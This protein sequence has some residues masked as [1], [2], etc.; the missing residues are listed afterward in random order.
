[1]LKEFIGLLL[2]AGGGFF[3]GVSP[4]RAA[5]GELPS[6][7][8]MNRFDVVVQG[9]RIIGGVG[10]EG[11]A[12]DIGIRDGR[13]A[14]MGAID[15]TSAE[16]VI[17][18]DG[19]DVTPGRAALSGSPVAA[20]LDPQWSW[21]KFLESGVTTVLCGDVR[22]SSRTMSPDS[23]E[24]GSRS[25]A[26]ELQL[27]S[28][29]GPKVNVVPMAG[30]NSL[31]CKALQKERIVRCQGREPIDSRVR[32]AMR[33]GA[34]GLAFAV[35]DSAGTAISNA[36]LAR[37]ALIVRQSCGRCLIQTAA[38]NNLCDLARRIDKVAHGSG[39]PVITVGD[40]RADQGVGD[41]IGEFLPLSNRGNIAVGMAADIVIRAASNPQ[42]GY[43]NS[44]APISPK[45]HYVLVNGKVA[46]REGKLTPG[47]EGHVLRGRG[48]DCTAKLA[49]RMTGCRDDRFKS[50]DILIQGF[51]EKHRLP[52]GAVAITDEG[53]L[54]YACGFGFADVDTRQPVRPD[55][56]FRIA[57]ISKPIT[58][59]AVMQ[60]VE[61]GKLELDSPVLSVLSH[62]LP[63]TEKQAAFDQRLHNVTIRQLLQHRAGWDREATFDPMFTAR[64]FA[65]A[66]VSRIPPSQDD[67][68][69]GMFTRPLDFTPGERYVYSNFGYCLLGRVIETLSQES[70]EEH[71]RRVVLTP[72]GIR[73]MTIGRTR[74]AQRR[75]AEVHYYDQ[76]VEMSILDV[77]PPRRVAAPYGAWSL[78]SMD[79]HGGW[80][81]SAV[82]LVR[83]AAAFDDP[84]H[85]ALLDPSSAK[86]MTERPTGLAGFDE[87]GIPRRVYYGLGWQVHCDDAGN[88][89]RQMHAGSLPGTSSVLVKTA[90]GRNLAIVFNARQS[91]YTSTP[92]PDL[93]TPLLEVLSHIQDWP[94]VDYFDDL[95]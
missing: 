4:L 47:R 68:I 50:V 29:F 26:E 90:S 30:F 25:L 17:D 66:G 33:A 85:C 40:S 94:E 76:G 79:S 87:E 27:L 7:D 95:Q 13:I 67:I 20:F 81:G 70:Y 5:V 59:V 91:P 14:A 89:L 75:P 82:D 23:D 49:R 64:R 12:C 16:E 42:E 6:V 53:R 46:I 44:D 51:L 63:N 52:G 22:T 3:L 32:A 71:V 37:L 60:L 8:P 38:T 34:F 78:E 69:R 36:D 45:I 72:I 65:H 18:A 84:E 77:D 86:S 15:L 28:Q 9:G 39:I 21:R 61:T 1:M 31:C 43:P 93:A 54:I 80:I 55:S 19:L 57:S 83:F 62:Y 41:S 10:M 58:A 56:L 35:D 74:L 2:V 24:I 92:A 11:Q 88:I 48:Y 73:G